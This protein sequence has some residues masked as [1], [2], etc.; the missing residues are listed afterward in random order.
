MRPDRASG[1]WLLPVVAFL[2]AL[3]SLS[4]SVWA[5]FSD[6][7]ASQSNELV[8]ATDVRAP[9]AN[10][11]VVLKAEGG[12]PGYVRPGGAYRVYANVND[13]G[14]PSSG[15]ETVTGDLT[16]LTSGQS[17][18]ALSQGSYTVAGQGYNYRGSSLTVGGGVSAGT[19]TYPLTLRDFAGNG[20]VQSGFPVVVDGTAATASDIQAANG[21]GTAGRADA[22]DTITFTFSEP[23]EPES[24]LSGWTGAATNVVVRLDNNVSAQGGFDAATIYNAANTGLLPLGTVRLARTDYVG[25]NRTFGATGTPSSMV[26]SGSAITITLGTA[27]GSTS[28]GSGTGTMIWFPSS[29]ATDRAGNSTSATSRNES[30]GADREF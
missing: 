28:T 16:A 23:I 27:S 1:R 21:T 14:N 20:A 30:G 6:R 8:A 18:A 25:A 29:G 3:S 5:A 17:A 26:Q 24:V 2:L 4:G 19:K 7:A 10:R 15:I 13:D 22:G 9:L 12:T 11:S